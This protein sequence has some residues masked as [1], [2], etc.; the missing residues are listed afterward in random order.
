MCINNFFNFLSITHSY[1]QLK[2]NPNF[3]KVFIVNLKIVA[4][5]DMTNF[6]TITTTAIIN[7]I[8]VA[9]YHNCY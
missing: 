9:N 2:I 1:F 5:F 4:Y 6:K 8:K 7:F 3:E